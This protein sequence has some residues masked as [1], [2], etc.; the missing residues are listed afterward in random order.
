MAIRNENEFSSVSIYDPSVE[1]YREVSIEDYKRML[2]SFGFE[3]KEVKE[4]VNA[5][6]AEAKAK[7]ESLGLSEAKI[8][9]ILKL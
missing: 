7:L 2:E 5:K 8:K 4:K 1:A 3:E 9:E 6:L